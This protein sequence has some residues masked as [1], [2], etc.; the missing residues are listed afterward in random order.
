MS[1]RKTERLLGLVVCLLSTRRYL[2]ADQIRQAVP[3]YPEQDELF[4][5]MFE[6]DKEDI[7]ELGIPLE[8]GFNHPFDDDLGYR[9]RQQAYELPELR[10]EADEAAVLGLAARVWQR[11]AL[12]GAA[13]GALLKLRAAGVEAGEER[14]AP[15]GIE[16]RLVTPEPTFGPLWEAVRD[17]R[18]V[19]FSYLA[20]GRSEPQRR[21]LEPWGVVN[22]YGRWYLVG[23]DRGRDDKR[24]FRLG[25]IAGAVKFCGPPGS[26]T[27]PAGTDVRKLVRD[28]APA[29]APEHTALLRVRSGGG[30][31]L[32]QHAVSVRPDETGPPGWDLVTTRFADVGWFADLVAEFGPDAVVLDPPDLRDAVIARLKGVLA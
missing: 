27:V 30:V 26:V 17:G 12:E 11:A 10:L 9:V 23:W 29:P 19:T 5:R 14:P 4:K 25:R 28:W 15:Q 20:P 18:P 2:T 24:V 32:R 8:T 7:R 16:P 13:A 3:G 6:R 31:G 21:E 1:K 22:R